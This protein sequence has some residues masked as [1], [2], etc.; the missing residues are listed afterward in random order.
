M[1]RFGLMGSIVLASGVVVATAFGGSAAARGDSGGSTA[2]AGPR[3][4]EYGAVTSISCAAPG[5]CAAGGFYSEQSWQA[6]VVNETNGSWGKPLEVPG[7]ATLNNSGD[8][9][10]ESVSCAAPGECAAGGYYSTWNWRSQDGG[11]HAFVV[12]ETNGRWGKAIRVRGTGIRNGVTRVLS[13]S[14]PASGACVAGGEYSSGG[15][16]HA[17][18]VAETSGVWGKAI[19]VPGTAA[20]ATGG[21]AEVDSISCTAVGECVAGGSYYEKNDYFEAFV[22]SETNGTWGNAIEV[23]GT[24]A[25]NS[26]GNSWGAVVSCGGAGECAAGGDYADTHDNRGAFVGTDTGGNWGTAIQP[27]GMATLNSGGLARVFSVSCA[28]VGECAAGGFYADGSG[29]LHAFVVDE[30]NGSW[31]TAIKVPGDALD[32]HQTWAGSL[33][34]GAPGDCS[35]IGDSF[36]SGSQQIFVVSE[37]NG[38]WGD[39]IN[40]PGTAHKPGDS[41]RAAISCAA[42]GEC[43]AGGTLGGSGGD[44]T[45][46]HSRAFVV[47]ERNGSWGDVTDLRFPISCVVPDVIGRSLS[48]A[49]R[50]IERAACRVGTIKMAYST[51]PPGRVVAERPGV[52]PTLRHVGARVG[53]TVSKGQRP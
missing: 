40:L 19:E 34:C 37:T 46:A 25:L 32:G 26:G 41:D 20:L 30:T 42:A 33:S 3:T 51:K 14:C 48:A 8:A 17:F 43:T 45:D 22:V 15:K 50:R 5:D 16:Q 52:F 6:F 18:V 36:R 10:V 39:A 49:R 28:A 27:P 4:V 7:T 24:D 38:T 23:P 31:G 1:R 13:V 12:T 53:L 29:H 35:A 9:K 44:F 11:S 47:D 2:T 21:A